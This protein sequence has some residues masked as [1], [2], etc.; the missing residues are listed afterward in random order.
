MSFPT[1]LFFLVFFWLD[2]KVLFRNKNIFKIFQRKMAYI[3]LE[4]GKKKRYNYNFKYFPKILS[5]E[6][7]YK[8]MSF[9]TFLC[10]FHHSPVSIDLFFFTKKFIVSWHKFFLQMVIFRIS[11]YFF[12]FVFLLLRI[13][14]FSLQLGQELVNMGC[15]RRTDKFMRLMTVITCPAAAAQRW[16]RGPARGSKSS[17]RARSRGL[18][19]GR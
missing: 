4:K 14:V 6:S 8:T 19:A 2:E 5:L 15:L 13:G 11:V 1:T 18:C 3:L 16:R 9:F 12:V 17:T 10:F 7:T